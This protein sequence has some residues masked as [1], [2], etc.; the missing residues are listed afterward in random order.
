MSTETYDKANAILLFLDRFTVQQERAMDGHAFNEWVESHALSICY[1][2][3][4]S[5]KG[6]WS[7]FEINLLAEM[8]CT[9]DS[10]R[11]EVIEEHS[12][13]WFL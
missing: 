1:Q 11:R 5:H 10:E 7:W 6:S 12:K 8:V 4:N 2:I 13:T 3:K 9:A